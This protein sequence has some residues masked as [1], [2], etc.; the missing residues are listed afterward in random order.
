MPI[1]SLSEAEWNELHRHFPVTE[2]YRG[3]FHQGQGRKDLSLAEQIRWSK[4]GDFLGIVADTHFERQ[5]PA[6]IHFSWS[7]STEMRLQTALRSIADEFQ[8]HSWSVFA[9]GKLGSHELNLSSDVDLVWIREPL[10]DPAKNV[11][12]KMLRKLRMLVADVT[13][14]GF[15]HRLDFDLRAGG[16]L[17]PMTSSLDEWVDYFSNYGEAWE[18][19]AFVRFRPLWGSGELLNKATEAAKSFTYRRFLDFSLLDAFKE[20]RQKIHEQNWQRTK[21]DVIDLKLGLG[22]I[23]DLELF[24]HTLQVVYGGKSP[25]VR[26]SSTAGALFEL[27]KIGALSNEDATFLEEHYWRLRTFENLVQAKNDQQTH[28]LVLPEWNAYLS[29][30]RVTQLRKDMEHCR[31]IVSGFL[32]PIDHNRRSLPESE[33]DQHE[34]LTSLGVSEETQADSWKTLAEDQ[35]LSRQ[36]ERDDRWRKAFIYQFL[37]LAHE[38]GLDLDR[39]MP[40]LADFTRKLKAKATF[41]HLLVHNPNLVSQIVQL[42]GSSDFLGQILI[43]RPELLDGF[44]YEQRPEIQ[45]NL[46]WEEMHSIWRDQKLLSEL[47]AG[48]SFLEKRDLPALLEQMSSVADSITN[49]V[50]N[51]LKREFHS[52]LHIVALGKWGAGELGL[53]SDLDFIFVSSRTPVQVDQQVA[54]R[55]L[56]R[57]TQAPSLF[58]V[59]LRLKPHGQ[60]GVLV[61]TMEDLE[62]FLAEEA[63]VWQRQ[64]YLRARHL[65]V[66]ENK[67]LRHKILTALYTR[68]LSA[69]DL[70]E[71][72]RIRQA[73]IDQNQDKPGLKYG[74]GGLVD[75]ELA[76]QTALLEHKIWPDASS[77]SSHFA[78][79]MKNSAAESTAWKEL[80]D[81]YWKLRYMEQSRRLSADSKYLEKQ[82][83][84]SELRAQ[85]AAHLLRLDP[86]QR[87]R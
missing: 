77:T 87:P 16:R 70:D 9:Y 81:L 56:S 19:L 71:L 1:P 17:G 31:E 84:S 66:S 32:G 75:I 68:N 63:P 12:A 80:Q 20:L 36:R 28:L 34:W 22:G 25:S 10:A 57:L 47:K 67:T 86:R 42:L 58:P 69:D 83:N 23:R 51:H 2:R 6:R 62:K 40:K 72:H 76:V 15:G 27:L 73:L 43:H 24:V 61:T 8:D 78:A 53:N 79:L 50:L 59:D 65:D 85:C 5:T 4:A 49:E 7:A 33:E 21:E 45:Q 37:T 82:D 44:V 64:V 30:S 14:W 41:F 3:I 55:F 39:L 46:S 74:P 38:R 60:S 35:V 29:E 11:D 54:R 26:L 52:D 18:R 48:L 13:P